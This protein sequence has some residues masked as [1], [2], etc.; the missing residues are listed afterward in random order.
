MISPGRA[1][2]RRERGHG[3]YLLTVQSGLKSEAPIFHPEPHQRPRL[4]HPPSAGR[5]EPIPFRIA[6]VKPGLFGFAFGGGPG[7]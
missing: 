5:L 2:L 4:W 6:F 7:G 1:S 3:C